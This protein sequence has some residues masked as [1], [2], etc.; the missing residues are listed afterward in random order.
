MIGLKPEQLRDDPFVTRFHLVSVGEGLFAPEGHKVAPFIL[1]S[2]S[3]TEAKL[4]I[5]RRLLEHPANR[6]W[7]E[8]IAAA[9]LERLEVSL[10]RSGGGIRDR[11]SSTESW[12]AEGA[13]LQVTA[14][15]EEE[16]VLL[17]AVS[18]PSGRKKGLWGI[19]GG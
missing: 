8:E 6:D 17:R 4:R 13:G 5:A 16:A 2:V 10:P 11:L 14:S 1:L 12:A 18:G 9:F 3:A 15:L 19:L 7:G